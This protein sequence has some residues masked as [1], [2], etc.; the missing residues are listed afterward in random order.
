MTFAFPLVDPHKESGQNLYRQYAGKK[1][2]IVLNSRW[3]HECIKADAL[4][5]F[6]SNWAGCKVDG[7]EQ[8]AFM[9]DYCCQSQSILFQGRTNRRA[10]RIIHSNPES[11]PISADTANCPG[12][13][14]RSMPAPISTAA[15]HPYPS[16]SVRNDIRRS[17]RSSS[18]PVSN[19]RAT[20]SHFSTKPTAGHH[21][22]TKLAGVQR[23]RY[24]AT[25]ALDRSPTSYLSGG[26][27]LGSS[28]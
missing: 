21:C 8:Y 10:K 1:G 15:A 27:A 20:P 17:P 25:Y 7:T 6:H 13:P 14:S 18:V 2:K 3:V 22:G 23:Y 26:T 28:I 19:V 16:N 12:T 5:T 11:R 9:Y 4:Q 24:T